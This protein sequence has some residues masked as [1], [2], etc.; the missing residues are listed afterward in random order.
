ML[1][2]VNQDPKDSKESPLYAPGTQVLIKIWKDGS[3]KAQ[4]Q[5]TWKG[6]Y[7]AIL[8]TPTVVKV[9]GHNS[10]THYSWVKPWKKTEED[11]QYTVSPWEISDTYSGL[12][13]SAILMNTPK[14]K[15]LGIRFLRVALKNQHNLAGVLLQETKDRS[16]DSWTRK[17]LSHLEWD[18]LF[19]GK[20]LQLS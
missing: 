11:T 15:F 8:S 10:W 18:M 6:P 13:M 5:P 3:P 19:L 1:V 12:Q 17:D 14:I 7:P 16:P 2:G 4:L 20:Y 9:P